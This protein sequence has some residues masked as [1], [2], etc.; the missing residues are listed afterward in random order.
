MKQKEIKTIKK[1]LYEIIFDIKHI[2]Q[3]NLN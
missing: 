2:T 1:R 3:K